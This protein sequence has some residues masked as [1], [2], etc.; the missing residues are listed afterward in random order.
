MK[1][2]GSREYKGYLF[3]APFF[4]VF[5]VLSLY[6]VVSTFFMSLNK[7]SN[8]VGTFAG[9]ANYGRLIKDFLFWKAFGNT[10]LIWGCNIVPQIASALVLGVMFTRYPP[11]GKGIL[12]AVYYFPNIVAMASIAM[13]FRYLLDWQNGAVN[14]FL[15]K[16]G[17]VET[18]FSQKLNYGMR[19]GFMRG[20]VAFIGWW[21]WFGQTMIICMAGLKAI[22]DDLYE[23]G[24]VDGVNKWQEFWKITLPL[25]KPTMLYVAITSLIGG[26]QIFDVPRLL[27]AGG[28]GEPD[29]SILTMILY[30][31]ENGFTA[32]A[33]NNLG[34]AAAIAYG[35]FVFIMIF[36]VITY[37][38]VYGG[39]L[40]E[41]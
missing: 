4:L 11:K 8:Y 10:L 1:G 30:L 21:Q 15:G 28:D 16:I 38:S 25:L 41:M 31:Y 37:R 39:A 24:V 32:T 33:S 40:D 12:R 29:R 22:P 9:F 5:F 7:Y 3:I 35:V 19:P 20:T 36:S 17:L 34:Y 27:T 6:P 13:L 18:P 23:A 2:I 14:I 26:M